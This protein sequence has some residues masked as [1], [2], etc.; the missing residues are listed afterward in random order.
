MTKSTAV[1][2]LPL[3]LLAACGSQT[4]IDCPAPQI[5]T[6]GDLH[7][8]PDQIRT[9]G[10]A[11]GNGDENAVA[12]AAEAVRARHPTA[13]ADAIADYLVV[14]YCPAIAAKPGMDAREQKRAVATFAGRA[15]RIVTQALH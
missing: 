3:A 6:A 4:S 8:T 2:I 11:I 7:E 1:L 13:G 5:G 15:R 10:A 12:V 9:T 14:A